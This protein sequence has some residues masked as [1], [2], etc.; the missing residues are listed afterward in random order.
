MQQALLKKEAELRAAERRR[1]EEWVGRRRQELEN[2]RR[3]ERAELDS[4][5][6]QH[7]LIVDQLSQSEVERRTVTQRV[8]EERQRCAEL[9]AAL[10]VARQQQADG[11]GRLMGVATELKVRELVD[12]NFL[13]E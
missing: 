9:A 5:R 2:E 8:Q 1:M 10:D 7:Q 6:H 11:R 4:I 12:N 3:H 13:L